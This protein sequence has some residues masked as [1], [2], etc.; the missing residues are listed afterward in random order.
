LLLTLGACSALPD[1]ADPTRFLDTVSGKD[2][3]SLD[4]RKISTRAPALSSVPE[5]PRAFKPKAEREE[6]EAGLIADHDNALDSKQRLRGESDV[7]SPIGQL[8]AIIYFDQDDTVL[9]SKDH[10]VLRAIAALHEERG[11][12]L[13]VVGHSASGGGNEQESRGLELSLER[14]K[15]VTGA[16]LDL[17]IDQDQLFAEAKPAVQSVSSETTPS[18]AASS[19]RVEIFLEN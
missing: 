5:E 2:P 18:T 11:G 19:R 6:L 17:G 14:A 12:K 3:G 1:W 13:R 8:A 9:N 7:A 10:E 4:S 15:T 16:L